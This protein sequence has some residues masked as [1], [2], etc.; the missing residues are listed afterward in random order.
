M[1]LLIVV[2]A[3]AAGFYKTSLEAEEKKYRILEIKMEKLENRITR[4]DF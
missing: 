2:L 4:M 1:F 3:F